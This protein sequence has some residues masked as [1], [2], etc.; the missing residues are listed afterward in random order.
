MG[1]VADLEGTTRIKLKM[2]SKR[3]FSDKPKEAGEFSKKYWLDGVIPYQYHTL[4]IE[5][6]KNELEQLMIND[7]RALKND[8]TWLRRTMTEN[9]SEKR[10]QIEEIKK[11]NKH[12]KLVVV[13]M[14][15]LF[16]IFTA[17]QI[18]LSHRKKHSRG[19]FRGI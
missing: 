1:T 11:E 10:K 6:G 14:T 12:I 16:G 15:C 3:P 2:T 17:A 19:L 13:I 4:E 5:D 18:Q 9:F 7:I 8:D